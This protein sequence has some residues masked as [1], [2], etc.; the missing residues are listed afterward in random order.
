MGLVPPQFFGSS[1]ISFVSVDA[2]RVI[3]YLIM[4][5]NNSRNLRN[6]VLHI[7]NFPN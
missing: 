5:H 6:Y 3:S 7:D 4:L 2:E 1:I